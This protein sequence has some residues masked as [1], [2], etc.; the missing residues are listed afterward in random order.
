MFSP[1]AKSLRINKGCML[2]CD[3]TTFPD[4]DLRLL[5][6]AGAPGGWARRHRPRAVPDQAPRPVPPSVPPYLHRTHAR[7]YARTSRSTVPR[8]QVRGRA[9]GRR[10][11]PRTPSHS[12]LRHSVTRV[13][14]TPPVAWSGRAKSADVRPPQHCCAIQSPPSSYRDIT[15]GPSAAAVHAGLGPP[16]SCTWV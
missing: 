12:R 7:T 15:S 5:H 14:R 16:R 8:L 4:L 6:A 13:H 10:G 9:L 2:A 3:I 11:V 1:P